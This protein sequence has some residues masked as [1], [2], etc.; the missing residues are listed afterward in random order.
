VY[1]RQEQQLAAAQRGG[2]FG[3]PPA[4]YDQNLALFALGFMES[5]YRFTDEGALA[6]AWETRCLGRAR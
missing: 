5:R 6:P 2:L 1:K 3:D 4:Y